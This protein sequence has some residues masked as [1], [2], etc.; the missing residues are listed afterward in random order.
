MLQVIGVR[1]P[2]S[3]LPRGDSTAE[4]CGPERASW[5]GQ[6]R[7]RSRMFEYNGFSVNP[8]LPLLVSTH[9]V[10]RYTRTPLYNIRS[11]VNLGTARLVEN[12]GW[13]NAILALAVASATSMNWFIINFDEACSLP[14]LWV[15]YSSPLASL[16]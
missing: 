9:M 2:V 12:Q 6:L 14:T 5:V 10:H 11:G 1:K 13:C 3:R 15:T 7:M 8:Y 16:Q 4:R